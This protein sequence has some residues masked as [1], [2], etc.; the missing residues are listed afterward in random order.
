MANNESSRFKGCDRV[1]FFLHQITSRIDSK[2][3]NTVNIAEPVF[4]PEQSGLYEKIIAWLKYLN[5]I[6]GEQRM[7]RLKAVEPGS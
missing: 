2:V 7:R 3:V 4:V 6:Y 5:L 1:Q